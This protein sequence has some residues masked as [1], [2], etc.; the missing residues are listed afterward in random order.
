MKSWPTS[1]ALSRWAVLGKGVATLYKIS[2]MTKEPVEE[3]VKVEARSL[4]GGYGQ[5]SVHAH[6]SGRYRLAYTLTDAK[7]GS[8][9]VLF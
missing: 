5:L 6:Q 9:R 7:G 2:T 3:K 8:V 1:W 4:R